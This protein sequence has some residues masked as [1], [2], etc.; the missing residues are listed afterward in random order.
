MTDVQIFKTVFF[1][2]MLVWGVIFSYVTTKRQKG[3][4]EDTGS[5]ALGFMGNLLPA[6]IVGWII[7]PLTLLTKNYNPKPSIKI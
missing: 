6:L 3:T 7:Y 2:N 4:I 5:F 1:G